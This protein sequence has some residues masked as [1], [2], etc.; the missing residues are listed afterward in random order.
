MKA[1]LKLA[2]HTRAPGECVEVWHDGKMIGVIY[3]ADGPGIRFMSRYVD[4]GTMV[5]RTVPLI[6]GPGVVE[7][8]VTPE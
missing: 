4:E 6:G 8:W 5:T 3:G 1:V 2:P 7:I